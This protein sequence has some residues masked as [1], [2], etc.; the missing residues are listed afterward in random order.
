MMFDSHVHTEV[1]ADSEMSLEAARQKAAALGLGL[2]LTEHQDFDY[3]GNLDFTFSPE[4]YWKKYG[5]FRE[6][7]L[8]L[9]VE[10]GLEPGKA[11]RCLDFIAQVPF[12]L[13]IGSIHLL[14]RQDIYY[15][16]FYEGKGQD[17]VYRQ[18]LQAMEA[19]LR[20][21][22][23]LDVCGHIDYIARY[24]P[25]EDPAVQYAAYQDEIDAVL[26]AAIEQDTLMEL[27]TRRLAERLARKELVPIYKR[28]HELGGRYVTLG[29]DAHT[30]DAI[31][32]NFAAAGELA[33]A[34][35]L[36]IVTFCQRKMQQI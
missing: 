31:G 7:E 11:A 30:E 4:R 1:S 17:E 16:E 36:K 2:V 24:A 13:V 14:E 5:A 9:G 20:E 21:Y 3:P 8:R 32:S 34:C 6:K 27:N 10:I 26:R 35:G 33:E 23:F 29:S 15:P 28:Y 25:Y 18:Y 19:C 22:P 12:D